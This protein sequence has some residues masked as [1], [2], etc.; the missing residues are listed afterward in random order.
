MR[1]ASRIKRIQPSAT[2]AM[3]EKAAELKRCNK[4]VY[5]LSVG[6]PDFAT[7]SNIQEA[8][9]IAINENHTKYTSE[10]GT[11]ELKK[12]ILTK[13][14][15]DNN[16]TYDVNNIIVSCGAKHSLYNACQALFEKNDEVLIFAPYWVSFPDFIAVTG[17]KPVFVKTNH[18][19]QFEPNFD[20][21][22]HKIT[23]KTK[24]IIIN[25]P[26]NPTGGVWSNEAMVRTLDVCIKNDLWIFS[27][28]CY[29]QFVYDMSYISLA[30][31]QPYNKLLTFQSCS[32]T[33]AMTGW[34]IGYTIGNSEVVSAMSKLQ[35]Q[36]TSCPNSIAQFAAIEALLGDQSSVR[37][38]CEAFK[39]RRDLI[40]KHLKNIAHIA[41]EI[42]SGA[43]YVF[44]DFSHYLG[45][46]T[47]NNQIIQTSTDLCLY[48]LN[49][50][51][52]VTVSGDSFGAPGH[53][54]ISYAT[55]DDII[56]KAIQLVKNTLLKL[57][58]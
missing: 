36:S 31:L 38:M 58:F 55:S 52:V 44:P 30:T 1:L 11:Y 22:I 5:N 12:A 7:P 17:A 43:F 18:Q 9:K 4:P 8:G 29:E 23:S 3:T 51:G 16:L 48:I 53:I 26:S 46:K 13:I 49:T 28:E 32:K 2:L 6:E 14:A 25:S 54:R 45:M 27:D 10:S 40:L 50:T 15:R 24:G 19:N 37:T 47:P 42:P 35:G 39:G 57:N 41:C 33:Y 20:D 34:R 56:I 21:L